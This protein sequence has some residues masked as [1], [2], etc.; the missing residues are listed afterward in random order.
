[1]HRFLLTDALG[2]PIDDPIMR[3]RV[4]RMVRPLSLA[5]HVPQLLTAP[6][7]LRHSG[8]E[9]AAGV[10]TLVLVCGIYRRIHVA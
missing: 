1:M 10:E 3:D 2:L 5:T 7:T 9:L 6:G 4:V 8:P